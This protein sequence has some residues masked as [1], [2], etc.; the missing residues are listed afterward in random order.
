MAIGQ[1]TTSVGGC[2]QQAVKLAQALIERGHDVEILTS[3]PLG[4]P[5]VER[6][7]QV[8]IQRLF[9]FGN[10]RGLW[11]LGIYS[12]IALLGEEL[13]RRRE[14]MDVVHV[15]QAFHA[16]FAAVATRPLHRRPVLVKVATAGVYG[17]LYQMRSGTIPLPASR[18]LL[19][20]VLDADRLVAISE[21]IEGELLAA[22]VPRP[23]I[24]RIP[25]GVTLPGEPVSPALRAQARRSLALSPLDGPERDEVVVYAGRCRPQKAPEL[26]LHAWLRLRQR[27]RC[28]LLILG[29]G[30]PEDPRFQRIAAECPRVRLCGR[31]SD[32]PRYLAAADVLLHP[33]R[34]EGLS[35]TLLEALSMGVPCVA[36]GI[37][38]NAE[39]LRGG[40]GLLS[41]PEDGTLLGVLCDALLADP[42]RRQLMSVLARKR[43]LEFE[44][45]GVCARYEA[46]Y[47]ELTE[48]CG[49][50]RGQNG[51]LRAMDDPE[52]R[53]ASLRA[54]DDER[55]FASLRATGFGQPG[56]VP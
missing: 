41:P 34:G 38:A 14:R 7:G 46:L 45:G 16:A 6:I 3:R 19:P 49:A 22:G 12:Y 5:A 21:E 8:P 42:R 23:H 37:R 31:V 50:G 13:L 54:T 2:E 55:R 47:E 18:H 43:A 1:L 48:E 36:S 9:I 30:F 39:L 35:N 26:I 11:R 52:R 44:M 28:H 51:R 29:D 15:H 33:S 27:P 56:D 20:T 25:N 10:R 53:F 4:S 40:A 32:V 24:C 17:D